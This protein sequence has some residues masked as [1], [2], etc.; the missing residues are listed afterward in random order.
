MI[1]LQS[2]VREAHPLIMRADIPCQGVIWVLICS[3][4]LHLQSCQ[5]A[6]TGSSRQA[7][8]DGSSVF[9]SVLRD[10]ERGRTRARLL[11][12]IYDNTVPSADVLDSDHEHIERVGM[13]V[14][15]ELD[16]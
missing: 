4:C 16:E 11:R 7:G 15:L 1:G 13:G 2:N 5:A 8:I 9:R 3:S 12:G 6:T 10:M 14:V